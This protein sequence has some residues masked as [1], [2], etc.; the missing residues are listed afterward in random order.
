[1]RRT[2]TERLTG[3]ALDFVLVEAE[4]LEGRVR[5]EI[6]AEVEVREGAVVTT[7]TPPTKTDIYCGVEVR[8]V[9]TEV[10][11]CKDR[12]IG[13]MGKAGHAG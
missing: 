5:M 13:G 12:L 2:Q 8:T 7:P 3:A 1:M 6:I 4:T 10:G 11:R 9:E